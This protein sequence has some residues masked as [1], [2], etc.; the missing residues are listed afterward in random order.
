VG[1]REEVLKKYEESIRDRSYGIYTRC[2][3]NKLGIQNYN[4]E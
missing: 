4:Y 1:G 3:N 2:S